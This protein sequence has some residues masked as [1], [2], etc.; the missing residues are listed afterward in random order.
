MEPEFTEAQIARQNDLLQ[1]FND[2]V[3]AHRL[4]LQEIRDNQNQWRRW[5]H[6]RDAARNADRRD[7][8]LH[9]RQR[10][11][12]YEERLSDLWQQDALARRDVEAAEA[13][14]ERAMRGNHTRA[15][16]GG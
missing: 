1:D 12:D 5:Q 3:H 4:L 6:R 9:A 8:F 2:L 11:I 7:E 13:R 10:V 16:E 15:E 14:Y